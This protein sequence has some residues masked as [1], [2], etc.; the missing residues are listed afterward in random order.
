MKK[1]KWLKIFLIT[2]LSILSTGLAISVFS[3]GKSVQTN[4]DYVHGYELNDYAKKDDVAQNYVTNDDMHDYVKEENLV[5]MEYVDT[6]FEFKGPKDYFIFDYTMLHDY[7][8]LVQ[9]GEM[10]LSFDEDYDGSFVNYS[11]TQTFL[12]F[13]SIN[14]ETGGFGSTTLYIN[15]YRLIEL[16]EDGKRFTVTLLVDL[17]NSSFDIVGRNILLGLCCGNA[18]HEGND[19]YGF[20][21]MDEEYATLFNGDMNTRYRF[22]LPAY[23]I[24]SC[25][26]FR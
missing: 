14:D 5:I 13:R 4:N 8:S 2:L 1:N 16:T 23:G 12:E 24:N 19:L 10:M 11:F 6:N 7:D 26:L 22:Y 3:P 9:F 21:F 25:M 18:D 20:T 17:Y 15:V